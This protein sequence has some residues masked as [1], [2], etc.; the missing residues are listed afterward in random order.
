MKLIKPTAT[1]EQFPTKQEAYA[2]I[3]SAGRTCYKSE[4]KITENSAADF[5]C[6][7]LKRGHLS[8]FEHVSLT[9]RFICDRGI[10][11]EL[12]R[13]R[14]CSFSQ[15][16]TRYCNYGNKDNLEFIIPSDWKEIAKGVYLKENLY[17]DFGVYGI[18]GLQDWANSLFV[19]ENTYNKLLQ[20]GLTPQF[21]RGVLPNAL[22]T[23]IVV[24][25]NLREWLH[26]FSMRLSKFAHPDM[27]H[28]ML[29]LFQEFK[30]LYPEIAH[31]RPE[32]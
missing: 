28:L 4:D 1:F 14:L 15:E 32:Q 12:V 13:H 3:E 10:T 22:K 27:V 31:I 29:M 9:A 6:M 25:A 21:A 20:Q 19:A 8:V 23:E 17:R 2:R 7:L 18:T 24:T 16:S 26:I 30:T 5:V 11:H